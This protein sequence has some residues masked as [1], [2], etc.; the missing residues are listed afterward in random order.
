MTNA[1]YTLLIVAVV[2]LAAV[3]L[4]YWITNP[5]TSE[6]TKLRTTTEP[7]AVRW[8]I[9]GVALLFIL[10]FL[11]CHWPQCLPKPCAKAGERIWKACVSLMRGPPSS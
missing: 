7:R 6:R 11:V 5:R 4:A 1:H 9:T 8:L 10:L 3:L 2:L